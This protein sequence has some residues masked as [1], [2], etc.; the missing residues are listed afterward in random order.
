[1]I[2]R[3]ESRVVRSV[4]ATPPRNI[5]KRSRPS[6]SA[7]LI[8]KRPRSESFAR[9]RFAGEIPAGLYFDVLA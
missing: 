6:A 8:S 4:P 7:Q 2:K 3:V 5:Q 1:M 9:Q